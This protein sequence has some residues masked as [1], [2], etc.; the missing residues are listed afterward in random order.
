M[1]EPGESLTT[2]A[3][4]D[5]LQEIRVLLSGSQVLTAFLVTLPFSSGFAR[6]DAA[7]RNVYAAT[8]LTALLSLIVFATPAAYHRLVWPVPDRLRFKQLGTRLVVVGL[9]PLSASLILATHLVLSEV[10][11]ERRTNTFTAAVALAIG[12]LWWAWPLVRRLRTR[13]RA[14]AQER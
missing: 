7:E 5:L 4:D 9:I 8:F 14:G 11:G 13:A 3:F 2:E 10:L 6:L 1:S 12:V